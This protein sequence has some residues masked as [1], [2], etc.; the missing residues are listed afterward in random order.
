MVEPVAIEIKPFDAL[1]LQE[2]HACLLL[3]AEIFVVDQRICVEADPDEF[4]PLCHHVLCWIGQSLAGTARLLPIEDGRVIKVGRVAV[5]RDH[6]RRGLGSAMMR[7]VQ[8]WIAVE[9]GRSGV[10]SA[11][12]YL[13]RW[14]AA[15]GWRR[16]GGNYIEAEID[17]L[18]MTYPPAAD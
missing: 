7:S 1:S 5:H 17:H 6:Q 14:Y 15:L 16:E 10:M 18:R 11:Q 3:R 4:D 13:E 12:A 9:P 2:L 8:D